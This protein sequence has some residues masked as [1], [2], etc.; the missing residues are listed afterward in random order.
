[1]RDMTGGG[2]HYEIQVVSEAFGAKSLIE[3]HRMV[4]RALEGL[5][6]SGQLHAIKLKT[7]SPSEDASKK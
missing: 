7:L 4:H 5:M 1:M 6:D 3:R 2:D